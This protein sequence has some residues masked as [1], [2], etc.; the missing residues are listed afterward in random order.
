MILTKVLV[1]YK[2]RF[3]VEIVFCAIN[4]VRGESND[5]VKNA[6]LQL[7]T[8]S[9]EGL[10]WFA[11]ISQDARWCD[12]FRFCN[13]VPTHKQSLIGLSNSS[14]SKAMACMWLN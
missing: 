10:G 3:S 9:Q 14:R 6:R 1:L 5:C 11:E 2:D 8:W 7:R 4:L 12:I 13:P